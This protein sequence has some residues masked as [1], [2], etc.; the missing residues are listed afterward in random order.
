[1]AYL[2]QVDFPFEGPFGEEMEKGFWDLAKVLTKKKDS[3]G[4]YGLRIKKQKLEASM[5]LKKNKMLK[6]TLKCI[7][8]DLKQL[9]LKILE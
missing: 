9:V 6:N 5:Y 2:L 8:T 1:M 7:R 4:K 3:I